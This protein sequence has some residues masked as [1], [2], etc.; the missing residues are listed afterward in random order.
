MYAIHI[1]IISQDILINVSIVN[2]HNPARLTLGMKKKVWLVH[3]RSTLHHNMGQSTADLNSLIRPKI[4]VIDAVRI[5]MVNGP[6]D[7]NLNDVKRLDTIVA[8][9][10]IVAA[11]SYATSFFKMKPDDLA[12][13]QADGAMGLGSSDLSNLKIEEFS[14]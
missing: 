2:H 8:G 14:V 13:L 10:D 1:V 12:Y 3:D 6:P 5:L 9:P 4:T 11:L 7:G